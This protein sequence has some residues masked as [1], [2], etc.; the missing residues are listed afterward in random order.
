MMSERYEIQARLLQRRGGLV[1]R[2]ESRLARADTLAEATRTAKGWSA[3]GFTVWI[4]RVDPGDGV[5]PIYHSVQRLE[6][7][8]ATLGPENHSPN[9]RPGSRRGRTRRLIRGPDGASQKRTG[10]QPK[11]SQAD[12]FRICVMPD[13]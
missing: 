9:Q 13:R 10:P 5:R 6:P 11:P 2:N 7:E 1:V 4:Y 3:D 12:R 8:A